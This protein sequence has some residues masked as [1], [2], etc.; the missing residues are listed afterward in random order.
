MVIGWD[1]IN[2]WGEE[3]VEI[4]KLLNVGVKGRVKNKFKVFKYRWFGEKLRW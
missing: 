3:L 4:S 1:K 2:I